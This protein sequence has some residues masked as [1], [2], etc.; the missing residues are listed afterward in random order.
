MS[1]KEGRI[2][3]L[4]VTDLDL[5]Q[6]A[7]WALDHHADAPA[8]WIIGRIQALAAAGDTEGATAWTEALAKLNE[9]QR[10]HPSQGERVH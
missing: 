1:G 5:W 8:D 3:V 6:A 2:S 4:M 7:Q 9:L 10:V